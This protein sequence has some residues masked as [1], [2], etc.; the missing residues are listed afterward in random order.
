MASRCT[1]P[2]PDQSKN[3][4]A[5]RSG[6]GAGWAARRPAAA[7]V[8]GSRP[9]LHPPSVPR[10]RT[11][12]RRRAG[13]PARV[14][15]VGPA[16]TAHRGR[17]R[18]EV[19]QVAVDY[20]GAERAEPIGS[21]IEAVDEGAHGQA[22][23]EQ[24]RVTWKPVEPWMPPAAPVTRMGSTGMILSLHSI[25]PRPVV[26]GAMAT[27]SG[28]RRPR[29]RLRAHRRRLVP[30]EP[31][32]RQRRCQVVGGGFAVADDLGSAWVKARDTSC[33]AAVTS[34]GI[35]QNVFPGPWASCGSI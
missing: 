19:A 10:R 17:D 34:L 25:L 4:S 13:P 21:V 20:F 8:T 22:L 15:E 24:N 31:H 18:S 3:C 12:R 2:T 14:G 27:R 28:S 23:V 32:R 9:A 7:T 26:T 1:A 33:R 30:P 35:T 6:F 11:S 29:L 5:G 16:D